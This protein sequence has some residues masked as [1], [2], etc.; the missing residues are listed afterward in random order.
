L[1][2]NSA[3]SFVRAAFV[4]QSPERWRAYFFNTVIELTQ[5]NLLIL[6]RPLPIDDIARGAEP[7]DDFSADS[8]DRYGP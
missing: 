1:A 5:Q 6:F 7:F 8:E 4:A 3:G 2:A